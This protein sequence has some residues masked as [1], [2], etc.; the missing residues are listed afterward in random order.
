MVCAG[1]HAEA[2]VL[3]PRQGGQ[4]VRVIR[5][6]TGRAELLRSR[7]ADDSRTSV[8]IRDIGVGRDLSLAMDV[9]RRSNDSV[10]AVSDAGLRLLLRAAGLPIEKIYHWIVQGARSRTLHHART[11]ILTGGPLLHVRWILWT[12]EMAIRTNTT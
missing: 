5:S 8:C 9:R 2:G 1:E 7:C 12:G 4:A 3:E 11:W 10:H 6:R